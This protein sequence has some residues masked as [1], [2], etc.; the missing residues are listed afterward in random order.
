[1]A[2]VSGWLSTLAQTASCGSGCTGHRH[3]Q[4]YQSRR[5]DLTNYP[6]VHNRVVEWD[7]SA[8]KPAIQAL[9]DAATTNETAG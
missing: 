2:R 6:G 7:Y 8:Y 9:Y 4:S 5:W 3:G 1:M